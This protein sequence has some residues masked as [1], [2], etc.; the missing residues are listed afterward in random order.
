ACAVG[1]PDSYRGE[2]V[3]AFIVP[4][5]GETLTEEDVIAFCKKKL[6]AYKVPKMIE[7]MDELPKSTVGKVLRREL[8]EREIERVK[9]KEG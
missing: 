4:R 5:E 1:I 3:K 8:R 6:A 7:F 2:T 9:K